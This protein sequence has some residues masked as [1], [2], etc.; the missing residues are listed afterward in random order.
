MSRP[1]RIG[2][3][4]MADV[5][6]AAIRARDGG[7]RRSLI[8]DIARQRELSLILVML[9]LGAGVTLRAPQFLTLSNLSQV[10]VL[11]SIT[12]VAAIGQA[13]V[14]ITRNI[15]LSVEAT[16]GLVA[17]VVAITL[18]NH[19]FSGPTAI[20]AGIAVGAILGMVIG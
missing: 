18:E 4:S 11:A 2:R 8:G 1:R 17:Y 6:V 13:L 3:S 16:M 9:V 12:A 7:G 15:D 14:L 19:V 5:R 10:A 20:V